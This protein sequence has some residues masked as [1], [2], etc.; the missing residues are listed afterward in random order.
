MGHW[1]YFLAFHLLYYLQ[2]TIL[3]CKIMKLSWWFPTVFVFLVIFMYLLGW[4]CH[5][6]SLFPTVA[7]FCMNLLGVVFA[8]V[9]FTYYYTWAKPTEIT[10]ILLDSNKRYLYISLNS[11]DKVQWDGSGWML[12]PWVLT[13]V[14]LFLPVLY[15]FCLRNARV[16]PPVLSILASAMIGV[17]T[18]KHSSC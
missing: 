18:S 15:S 11:I 14:R 2:F 16:H 8:H 13:P 7:L 17:I 9:Y 4:I 6:V 3:S 5:L 1:N 12:C 10:E